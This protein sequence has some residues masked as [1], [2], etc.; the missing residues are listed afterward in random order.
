MGLRPQ[1][2]PRRCRKQAVVTGIGHT[3]A[4][5]T[6]HAAAQVIVAGIVR[7]DLAYGAFAD[8]LIT[9][10]GAISAGLEFASPVPIARI[11]SRLVPSPER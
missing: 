11:R 7:F 9:G 6:S 4:D 2:G 10:A 3:L 5:V 8:R 1:L